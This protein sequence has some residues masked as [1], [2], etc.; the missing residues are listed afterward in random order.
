MTHPQIL[1]A[2]AKDSTRTAELIADAFFALDATAWLIPD[3]DER[4]QVLPADFE[5]YVDHALT[6][7]ETHLIEDDTGELA[8]AAVWFPQLTGPTPEPDNYEEQLVA[9]C[10]NYTD[11]FRT[12]DE[13]CEGLPRVCAL[14]REQVRRHVVE[15]FDVRRMV[16]GYERLYTRL[17][18]RRA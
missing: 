4:A 11:R 18:E 7:G 15:N 6:Y 16:D 13:L 17:S 5:I 3:P 10:G 8:A 9:T 12:L 14:P 2:T 1:R